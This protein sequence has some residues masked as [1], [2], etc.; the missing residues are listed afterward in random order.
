MRGEMSG[1]MGV[2]YERERERGWRGGGFED[3]CVLDHGR[4]GVV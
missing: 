1:L 3:G 2:G 4:E